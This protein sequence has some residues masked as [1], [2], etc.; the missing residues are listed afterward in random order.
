MAGEQLRQGRV[1][2]AS[3]G[4]QE[5]GG[6]VVGAPARGCSSSERLARAPCRQPALSPLPTLS[7]SAK[8]HSIRMLY[9]GTRYGSAL[10][11]Y[12]SFVR[13]TSFSYVS[14]TSPTWGVT[15]Q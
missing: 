1:G 9:D 13:M 2:A 11:P 8:G 12:T 6:G 10:S 5:G 14:S 4:T 15:S 3:G 7:T